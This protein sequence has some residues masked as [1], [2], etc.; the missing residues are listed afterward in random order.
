MNTTKTIP[1]P[2]NALIDIL[3]SLPE[4]ILADVFWKTFVHPDDAPLTPADKTE[5]TKAKDEFR[6]HQT[7][8]WQ[9]IR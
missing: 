2:E 5:I 1:V 9:D 6:K 3:K 8:K 4:N 7:I